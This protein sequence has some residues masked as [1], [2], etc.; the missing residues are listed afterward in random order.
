MAKKGIKGTGI[1]ERQ[2]SINRGDG[3]EKE[4]IE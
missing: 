3:R 1:R 4:V 2:Q